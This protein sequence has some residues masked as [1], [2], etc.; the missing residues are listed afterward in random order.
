[1]QHF[2]CFKNFGKRESACGSTA[3][4]RAEKLERV[5]GIEPSS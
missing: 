2:S 5:K 3:S 1:M 4:G